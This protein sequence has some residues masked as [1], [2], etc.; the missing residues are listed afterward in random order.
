MF[1]FNYD[2]VVVGTCFDEWIESICAEVNRV[3]SMDRDT[4]LREVKIESTD[5]GN[6]KAGELIE[7]RSISAGNF[8]L[9]F[10]KFEYDKYIKKSSNLEQLL[11]MR[12]I[13]A[14]WSLEDLR[15]IMFEMLRQFDPEW[16]TTDDWVH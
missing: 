1:R 13:D 10:A 2:N 7:A 16:K 9:S 15:E 3:F 4:P 5:W 6:N 11:S 14:L 12:L 8:H